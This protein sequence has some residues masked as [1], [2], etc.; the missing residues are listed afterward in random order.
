VSNRGCNKCL[1]PEKY[2]EDLTFGGKALFSAGDKIREIY[3]SSE[4]TEAFGAGAVRVVW[5]DKVPPE[6]EFCRECILEMC[7]KHKGK[8]REKRVKKQAIKT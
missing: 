8:P 1:K 6:S 4:A 3:N 5:N 7:Q 2:A